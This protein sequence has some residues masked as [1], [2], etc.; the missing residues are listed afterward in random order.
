ML[1]KGSEI[2]I[3]SDNLRDDQRDGAEV[4]V[5]QS[6]TDIGHGHLSQGKSL[7]LWSVRLSNC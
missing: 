3:T 1:L 5:Q 4:D 6:Q 7:I 2:A